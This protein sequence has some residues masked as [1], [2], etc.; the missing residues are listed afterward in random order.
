G[1]R[2]DEGDTE[3]LLLSTINGGRTWMIQ[4]MPNLLSV[5]F[6][7]LQNGWAV[8]RNATLL[9]TTK[10][11]N[12]WKPVEEIQRDVG[13]PVESSN[14]KFGFRVFSFLDSDHVW[15]IV[16]F[17]GRAQNNIAGLFATADGGKTWT[18]VPLTLKTQHVSGRFT[19][20]L[21]HSVHFTD[22]N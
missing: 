8:G 5:Y 3:T 9:H 17:Y 22:L 7:D 19:P 16:N 18:R 13:L 11:G 1:I 10:G 2:K 6:T 20:G 14:F 21:L 15:L 12:D 4:K